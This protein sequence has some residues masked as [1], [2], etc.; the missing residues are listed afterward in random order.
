MCYK[1]CK[2]KMEAAFT[3]YTALIISHAVGE[4]EDEIEAIKN[5][6]EKLKDLTNQQRDKMYNE[7]LKEVEDAN[8]EWLSVV[9]GKSSGTGSESITDNN[10]KS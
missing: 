3:K 5:S 2:A 6:L 9:E 4:S 8:Q 7:K 1:E 10:K